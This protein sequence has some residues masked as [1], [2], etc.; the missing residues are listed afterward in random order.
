MKNIFKILTIFI[1]GILA[2][3]LCVSANEKFDTQMKNAKTENFFGFKKFSLNVNKRNAIFVKPANPRK[4]NAWVMR[5]AFFGAFPKADIALL[6]SGFYIAYYDL[7]HLYASPR[8]IKLANEFY[9]FATEKCGLSKKVGLEGISRGGACALNWGNSDPSK[10]SAIYV[11]APVCDFNVWPTN[12]RLKKDLL[13]EW[14]IKSMKEF[15][16]NPFDNLDKLAKSKVPVLIIAGDSDK[17]VPYSKNG[18]IYKTRFEK[19]GG[20][21]KTIVKKGCDHHPHGLDDSTPIVKFFEDAFNA[22]EKK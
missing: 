13:K 20:N 22:L 6:K 7:T 4:D 9:K 15:K 5:P 21:I 16:G 10:F 8:A 11:D 2:M 3:P 17:P 18:E 1:F 19:L 14:N 12:P